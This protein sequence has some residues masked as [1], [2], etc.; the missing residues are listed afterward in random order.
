MLAQAATAI[1]C[2]MI[3]PIM[4]QTEYSASDIAKKLGTTATMV[5]RIANKL[6]LK[7]EQPGQNKYGRWANSKSQYSNKEVAQWLYT[8]AGYKAIEKEVNKK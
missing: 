8:N 4:K 2:E 6:G 3:V 5:G 1:T 7:A